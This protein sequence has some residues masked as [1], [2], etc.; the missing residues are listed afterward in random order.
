[1]S[2][3]PYSTFVESLTLP[4]TLLALVEQYH[5][6]R[7]QNV[8]EET[9]NAENIYLQR[10]FKHFDA[11]ITPAELFI[12][13]EPKTITEYLIKYANEYGPESRKKMQKTLR[14]FLRFAYHAGYMQ[15]DL[16][17]LSPH[18]RSPRMGKIARAI[19]SESIDELVSSIDHQDAAALRDSAIIS[20]LSTYG[21]RGVQVRRL[22]MENL[23][24]DNGRILFRA[25]K[26]GRNVEQALIPSVGNRLFDY[27]TKGRPISSH[28]EVFLTLKE[29][30]EPITTSSCL[31]KIIRDRFNQAGI[32]LPDG[33]SYGSHGF[34]HSFASNLY[35][36]VPFKDLVDMLG[37]RDPSTT[38][39]Y[40]KV[41]LSALRETALP[42]PGGVR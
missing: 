38:L 1:M 23:D 20:M 12:A 33:V 22:C 30:F 24:W 25:V 32:K 27:I 10:L 16:S 13:L 14:L 11:S 21:V 4:S 7:C 15:A 35:G 29:P 31:S 5:N 28:K 37:H 36:L 17:A 42:W 39:I 26:G 34:R 9:A 8:I 40:G 6:Q 2:S 41:D 3:L 18:V 19:P